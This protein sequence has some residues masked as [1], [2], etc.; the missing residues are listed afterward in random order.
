[1]YI[2][3]MTPQVTMSISML[4]ACVLRRKPTQAITD[5][6][7]VTLR[8]PNFSANTLTTGPRK[9]EQETS[10]FTAKTFVVAMFRKVLV[11]SSHVYVPVLMRIYQTP[12]QLNYTSE[13]TQEW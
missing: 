10:L 13:I 7:I 3:P 11:Q 12:K 1:M 5:P 8:D 9:H 4:V 6:A 2:P